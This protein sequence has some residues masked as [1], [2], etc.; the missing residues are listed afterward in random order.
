MQKGILISSATACFKSLF[1]F[2]V[3]SCL[4][5][6]WAPLFLS[7]PK[8]Q[9]KMY[10]PKPQKWKFTDL[11]WVDLSLNVWL[12]CVIY[13]CPFEGVTIDFAQWGSATRRCSITRL[14]TQCPADKTG[15]WESGTSWTEVS[16]R[17]SRWCMYNNVY[18]YNN[19]S[20]Q[21]QLY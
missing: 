19:Y 9:A 8:P 6:I 11:N 15:H 17:N 18:M 1:P 10:K 3:I 12:I 5:A 21:Q 7:P 14:G 20:K 2:Q 13:L 16:H 4:G